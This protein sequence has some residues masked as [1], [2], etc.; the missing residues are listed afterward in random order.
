MFF[1]ILPYMKRYVLK[2]SLA[3][4]LTALLLLF[5]N[6][7]KGSLTE[8]AKPYLGVYECRQATLGDEEY[9][10]RFSYIEL[11]LSP[12]GKYTLYYCEK[13]G[14]K[15]KLEGKYRYDESRKTL[16]LFFRENGLLK[17]D[18]PLDK[19]VLTITLP[20]NGE[21]LVMQFEQK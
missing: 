12:K 4:G 14:E 5:P 10:D 2:S 21:T 6:F 13:E 3:A 16:T 8:I 18:F 17:R 11:E 1:R 19:G 20:L 9:L 15:Q 7:R